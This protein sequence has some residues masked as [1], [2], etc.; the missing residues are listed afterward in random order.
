[1]EN[2]SDTSLQ[3]RF[4]G[5][6]LRFVLAPIP[7]LAKQDVLLAMEDVE[8]GHFRYLLFICFRQ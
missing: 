3:H 5:A 4:E 6:A 2:Q 1:M 7:N 8:K